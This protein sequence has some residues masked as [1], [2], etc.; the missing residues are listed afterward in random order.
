MSKPERRGNSVKT[1]A[2][3]HSHMGHFKNYDAPVSVDV[4][5]WAVVTD[6]TPY[7]PAQTSGPPERCYEAEGGDVEFHLA[8]KPGGPESPFLMKHCHKLRFKDIY[9]DLLDVYGS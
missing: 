2:E 3:I 1:W 7:T 4:P 9:D 6:Y 8:W 5:C